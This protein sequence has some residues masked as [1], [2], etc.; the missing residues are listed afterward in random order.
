MSRT[1]EVGT[2]NTGDGSEILPMGHTDESLTPIRIERIERATARRISPRRTEDTT[3]IR[4]PIEKVMNLRSVM[5][6]LSEKI[7]SGKS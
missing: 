4:E 2:S 6:G 5:M 1:E 3:K 7:Y